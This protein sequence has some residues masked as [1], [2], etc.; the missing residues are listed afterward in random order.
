MPAGH[1]AQEK[2][3]KQ[4]EKLIARLQQLDSDPI[5]IDVLKRQTILLLD[6]KFR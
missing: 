5:V 6:G 4:E 1:Y 2:A 3:M